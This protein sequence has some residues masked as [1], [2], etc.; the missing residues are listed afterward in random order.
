MFRKPAK[1]PMKNRKTIQKEVWNLL[2]RSIP[3]KE[4]AKIGTSILIPNWVI[5]ANA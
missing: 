1:A 4:Q 5:I 3:T 2:S